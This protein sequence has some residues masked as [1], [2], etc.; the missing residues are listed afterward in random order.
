MLGKP[1]QQLG[2]FRLVL[3]RN[4][5]YVTFVIS[6]ADKWKEKKKRKEERKKERERENEGM[7]D[8]KYGLREC[9][10]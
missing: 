5:I 2:S 7:T 3:E 9:L 8:P 4:L 1:D 10:L 6:G